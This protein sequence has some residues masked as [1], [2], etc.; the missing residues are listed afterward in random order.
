MVAHIYKDKIQVRDFKENSK[1]LVV[2][3][4][5]C[6]WGVVAGRAMEGAW[7]EEM[8]SPDPPPPQP[9]R[10]EGQQGE[11]RGRGV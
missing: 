6:T 3:I 4:F 8:N 1:E 10:E 7:S 9:L 11:A 5:T 2:W